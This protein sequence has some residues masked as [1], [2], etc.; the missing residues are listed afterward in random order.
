MLVTLLWLHMTGKVYSSDK[1]AVPF[2]THS[3]C[4][5][6]YH[7]WHLMG[8][9]SP[10]SQLFPSK[11]QK[12]RPRTV[13][14][15]VQREHF[16]FSLIYEGV[17]LLSNILSSCWLRV[18]TLGFITLWFQFI[19]PQFNIWPYLQKDSSQSS[20]NGYDHLNSQQAGVLPYHIDLLLCWLS[21]DL[22]WIGSLLLKMYLCT[23][24][25]GKL[26]HKYVSDLVQHFDP[27]RP[28]H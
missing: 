10:N 7:K 6:R 11:E 27:R 13:L 15:C 4:L 28:L 20:G 5:K 2:Y 1:K 3:R 12:C 23:L 22:F 16:K 18:Q 21:S 14:L 25:S 9:M 8:K 24:G 17:L 19:R 26:F